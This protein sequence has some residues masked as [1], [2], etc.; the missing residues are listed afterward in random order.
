M[1][2]NQVAPIESFKWHPSPRGQDQGAGYQIGGVLQ[3]VFHDPRTTV[4][5]QAMQ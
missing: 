5:P 2:R 1:Q 4:L 3:E